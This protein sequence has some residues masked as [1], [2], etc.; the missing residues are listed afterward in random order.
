M[1]TSILLILGLPVASSTLSFL[2]SLGV[3]LILLVCLG[4]A[5]VVLLGV[6]LGMV[7]NVGFS[8][9]LSVLACIAV[10]VAV[11]GDQALDWL[12]SL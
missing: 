7:L 9:L 6:C 4:L 10:A 3:L 12:N 5:V 1:F 11:F 8:L 2:F